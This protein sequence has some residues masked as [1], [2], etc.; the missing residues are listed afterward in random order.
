[1]RESNRIVPIIGLVL[2]MLFWGSSFIAMKIAFR[3]YEPLHVIFWR[4]AIASCCFAL[5]ARRFVAIRLP[6]GDWKLLALMG[7]FEPCL[8]FIF[9]ALAL[10]QTSAAQAGMV[11]AILPLMVAV[12]AAIWLRESVTRANIA[13]FLLAIGGVWWLSVSGEAN[14]HAPNPM[15]GNFLELLAMLCATGY[16]ITL[17]RLTDRYSPL[18]LTAMQALIGTLFFFPALFIFPAPES[19]P[20]LTGT[21]TMAVI[22]LGTV[23]T[24]FAYGLYNFGVSRIPVSQASAYINL[25]P[26]FSL[27]LGF[28]ILGERFTLPQ[29]LACAVVFSGV[30]ISQWRSTTSDDAESERR[31][32]RTLGETP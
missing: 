18:F 11:T 28:A 21:A 30:V 14:E 3:E 23:V 12:I 10:E 1:M 20:Q 7:L 29:L 25:I 8:Y 5:I 6:R 15:L 9:E 27:I 22:Y 19:A 16:I 17:K 2:A 4:L 24:I 32:P 13:G 26:V 31:R